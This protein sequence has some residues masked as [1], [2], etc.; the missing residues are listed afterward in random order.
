MKSISIPCWHIFAA[1]LLI[2]PDAFGDD[3]KLRDLGTNA[4]PGEIPK[5]DGSQ[6]RLSHDDITTIEAGSGLIRVGADKTVTLSAE[7]G[8]SGTNTAIARFADMDATRPPVGAVVAWLK[9]L[10]NTPTNLSFGWVECNGQVLNDTNSPY[11]GV[12]VPNLNSG[13]DVYGYHLRG[14]VASG[15]RISDQNR[16][17]SHAVPINYGYGSGSGYA[18]GTT[19]RNNASSISSGGEGGSEA[20]VKAYT[21]V[22]IMRVK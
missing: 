10:S 3:D 1:F 5:W 21:V 16:S 11:H 13:Q 14:H 2:G 15:V 17:H 6:W 8:G 12:A 18:S 9:S 4:A 20:R 19:D 22:W 7:L